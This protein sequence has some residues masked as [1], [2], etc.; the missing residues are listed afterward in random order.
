MDW[1]EKRKKMDDEL[2]SKVVPFLRAKSFKGS[3]PHFKRKFSNK[4]D[5][6]GF[7]FSQWGPQFYIE[8]ATAPADGITLLNGNH[9]PADKI[10]YYQCNKRTRI[11]DQPFDFENENFEEVA[12]RVL[13]FLREAEEWWSKN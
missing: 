6:L 1:K 2:K 12:D 13:K 4:I 10:K 9:F 3:L 11:G 7:Q 8:I 5:I